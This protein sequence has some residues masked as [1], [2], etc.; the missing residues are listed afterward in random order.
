MTLSAKIYGR[1]NRRSLDPDLRP[2]TRAR[3]ELRDLKPLDR[4]LAQLD[5]MD[6]EYQKTYSGYAG[7]CPNHLGEPGRLNFEVVELERDTE[8]RTGS[9][10]PSGSVLL[11]C[12]AYGDLHGPDGCT[13]ARVIKALGLLPCDLYPDVAGGYRP[14][15]PQG[16]RYRI[17]ESGM[18][19]PP[20]SDDEIE[21]FEEK[22]D[23]FE[24]A[25]RGRHSGRMGQLADQLGVATEALARF[26]VGWRKPDFHR[27]GEETVEGQCWT[28]PEQD[29]WGRVTAINRRYEDGEKRIM[30]GGR[31]GLY[32][33]DGWEDIPGPIDLPEGFSDAAALVA[34]GACAIGRPSVTGG[35]A[36]LGVLLADDPRSIVILGENDAKP[37]RR[38]GEI[39]MEGGETVLRH[40]G[41][42]GAVAACRKLRALLR[43]SDITVS[44]PPQGFKDIRAFLT[45][46]GGLS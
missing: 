30:A 13:Q 25:I 46:K 21:L 11:Y 14:Y 9:V 28:I 23:R 40:P 17:A 12:Q 33:P 29:G 37:V 4:V 3:A 32:V 44:M 39:V 5:A 34:R 45:R 41:Y 15:L 22:T 35:V 10:L 36:E 27:V 43:R 7:R 31:R 19:K 2:R 26:R 24:A 38:D 20:L 18:N 16:G 8:T 1:W 6:L 42:D